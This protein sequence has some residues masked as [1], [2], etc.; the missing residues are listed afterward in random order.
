MLSKICIFKN[1]FKFTQNEAIQLA[2]N[3]TIIDLW[4]L[5]P[6]KDRLL[7]GVL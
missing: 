1:W 2:N 7:S 5:R 4:L 3:K 6:L